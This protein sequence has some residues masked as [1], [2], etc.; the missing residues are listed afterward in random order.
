MALIQA[1]VDLANQSLGK[2]GGKQV[3]LT[4]VTAN[5]QPADI[6]VNL[7]F[8]QTRNAL[9]R[10]YNWP[11]AKTRLRLV[12]AWL[13]DTIYTT[14]QYVWQSAL[15]YKCAIAHTS[16]VFT[17][18]LAAVKWTLVSTVD[19]WATLTVYALGAIVVEDA[20]LYRALV[21]HTAGVFATDLAAGKWVVTTTKPTNV[22]GFNYDMP[23]NSLRL[24]QNPQ[25]GSRNW[26]GTYKYPTFNQFSD[27]WQLETNTILTMD[28]DVDIVYIDTITET[29]KW[30]VLFTDLFVARFAKK[31]Y[32]PL[33]GAGPGSAALRADLNIEIKEL[34]SSAR[35]VGSAEGNASGASDWNNAR[36]Q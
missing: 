31:L 27:T 29:T 15:L 6:Q 17:T 18:D 35:T 14:D 8:E 26:F 33:A 32:A 3:T 21:A 20:V 30:D 10:S 25:T 28:I 24:V 5:S 36:F 9:L 19:A 7:H 16:D 22:F 34:N 2:I 1:E 4:S 11:F 12:S 13:T 23:A